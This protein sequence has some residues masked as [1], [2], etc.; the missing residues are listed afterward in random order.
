MLVDSHCHLDFPGLA[1]QRAE[2]I[3]RAH[4]AD[5]G[6][7]QTIAT[8]LSTFDA[9]LA[10]AEADSGIFC[11]VGVHPHQADQEGVDDPAPLVA[12]AGHPKVIGIGESG[13][14]YFYDNSSRAGQERS[15]RAHIQAARD[16]G[17]PLIVHTR[18]ADRDTVDLLRAAMTE[19]PFAGV[20]HCYSSSPELG[21]AAVE[22]GLYLGIGGILTFKR[23]EALRATVRTLPLD[24][25]VLETDAPYLA[26]Q[27]VRGKRNEPAYVAHVAATPA[28]VKDLPFV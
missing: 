8:R 4:A 19:A 22:M 25:L 24:R 23:S 13:L 16:T 26:P 14:D 9:V 12:R 18:D 20:I 5:V 2:V 10:I 6:V 27:P 3:E 15:F 17:L 1:E 28:D 7:M 11:S 21:F